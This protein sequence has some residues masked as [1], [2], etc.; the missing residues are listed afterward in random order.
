[1]P[2]AD[3][4]LAGRHGVENNGVACDR[5]Q[6][7]RRGWGRERIDAYGRRL[8]A[9]IGWRRAV[10]GKRAR[11][12]GRIEVPHEAEVPGMIGVVRRKQILQRLDEDQVRQGQREHVVQELGREGIRRIGHA[13]RGLHGVELLQQP[14]S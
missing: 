12:S 2:V 6:R 10:A 1:V 4:E 3:G 11:R 14:K 13:V 5:E 9:V 7:R 8:G